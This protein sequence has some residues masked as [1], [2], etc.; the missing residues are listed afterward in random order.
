MALDKLLRKALE[1][2][3][4]RDYREAAKLYKKILA[5]DP[6][7]LDGN[8]LLGTLYAECGEGD[9]AIFY[10]SKACLINPMSPKVQVNLGNVYLTAGMADKAVSHYRQAIG[11]ASHMFEAHL[12]LGSALL[13]LNQDLDQA[14]QAL[15][16][17]AMLAPRVP[18]IRYTIG[19]LL[20]RQGRLDEAVKE[21]EAVRE[22]IP[23]FPRI[24]AV[25]GSI[26][27]QQGNKE[28]AASYF[29]EGCR[30]NPED[31]EC[32]SLL[33]EAEGVSSEASA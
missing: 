2:H 30:I 27:L 13:E 26:S 7:H 6:K 5:A 1:K 21:L 17:A 33:A 15:R 4:K 29:R 11:L 28:T 18:A 8:Y 20:Q 22:M 24:N 32:A 14:E 9:K 25:L 12:G 16:K 3:N 10:L 19:M 23:S 31:A